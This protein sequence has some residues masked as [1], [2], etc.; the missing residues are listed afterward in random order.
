LSIFRNEL[1]AKKKKTLPKDFETLLKEG[2]VPALKAVFDGCEP[3]ARGG[4]SKQTALAFD[5]C[6][7]EL[8]AWLVEQGADLEATDTWGNTPLHTRSRSIFGN[9]SSL[10]QLGANVHSRNSSGNTPLHV[11]AE[12]H[13]P[14]NTALLIAQGADI[15]GVNTGGYSPLVLALLTC[16]N[17]DIVRAVQLSRQY[18]DAGVQVTP[19]MQQAVMEIGKRFEFHRANFNKESVVEFSNALD[20]LYRLFGATPVPKRILHDG[21]SPITVSSNTWQE[22]HQE[23]WELLVPSSGPAATIQGEVIR[24]TGRIGHELEGNGGVNWDGDF[25]KM[26][27]AFLAFVQQGN[28][29]AAAELTEAENI[30]KEIKQRAGDTRRMYALGVQWVLNNPTPIQLPA[31]EYK[32]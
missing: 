20:D 28:A 32:R 23:L 10:L 26:A 27:D 13:N 21:N 17:I 18:L 29:L 24:I 1:M 4:Y 16:S 2:N 11:A 5:K 7:H 19:A 12:G 9:I 14:E 3:D 15:N 31:V 25:K 30:V 22:Q 6:P 8:A